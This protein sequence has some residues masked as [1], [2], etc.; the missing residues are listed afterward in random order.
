[1]RTCL[2]FLFLACL[3]LALAKTGDWPYEAGRAVIKLKPEC[4]A[5]MQLSSKSTGIPDVD[6]LISAL[7]IE[8]VKPRFQTSPK[9]V[10]EVDL[11]TIL[12]LKF[13][14]GKEPIGV[15]NAFSRLTC[16]AY[17]EPI[18]IDEP[19]DAPNDYFFPY[20]NY[21]DS[22]YAEQAWA[23]HKGENGGQEVVIAIV[24][25]GVNWNTPIWRKISGTTWARTPTPTAI[26][27]STTAP[28][29][30]TTPGT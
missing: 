27:Y 29:G 28:P 2:I 21:L 12:E 13:D 24:D 9:A 7:G 17:A 30:F 8:S 20:M 22:L 25:T 11:S 14:R 4:K 10:S 6:R 1:M 19:F 5:Q 26:R 15:C 16:V 23:I 18:Y 3:T